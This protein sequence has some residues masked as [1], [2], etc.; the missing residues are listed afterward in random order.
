MP[1]PGTRI[2]CERGYAIVADVP[3]LLECF[4]ERGKRLGELTVKQARQAIGVPKA[5]PSRP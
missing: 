1:E 4:D 5:R 3:G 2:E